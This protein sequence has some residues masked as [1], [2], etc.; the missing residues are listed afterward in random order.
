MS[1]LLVT[2]IEGKGETCFE[3]VDESLHALLHG[4]TGRRNE[5]VVVDFDSTSG[6]LVQALQNISYVV[7]E[8]RW[9]GATKTS[10]W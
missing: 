10:T 6:H 8:Q 2:C 5:F 4:S 9:I 7:Q 3:V 1:V